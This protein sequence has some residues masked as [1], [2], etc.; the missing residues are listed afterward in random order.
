MNKY[1]LLNYIFNIEYKNQY[2]LILFVNSFYK[3]SGCIYKDEFSNLKEIEFFIKNCIKNNN[4]TLDSQLSKY[5]LGSKKLYKKSNLQLNT[6]NHNDIEYYQILKNYLLIKDIDEFN[7]I[8]YDEPDIQ[9][10][11]LI[12]YYLAK[13]A[14]KNVNSSPHKLFSI[15][16]L[17]DFFSDDKKVEKYQNKIDMTYT[18]LNKIAKKTN[19]FNIN[20]NKSSMYHI[21]EIIK[22]NKYLYKVLISIRNL[23][24]TMY[25]DILLGIKNKP[26]FWYKKLYCKAKPIEN[27]PLKVA[28]HLHLYYMS[29]TDEFISYL[30]NIPQS[31]DLFVTVSEDLIKENKVNKLRDNFENFK[32]LVLPSNKG[33]DIGSFIYFLHNINLDDYDLI[34]KIHTKKTVASSFEKYLS[35]G[36]AFKNSNYKILSNDLWRKHNL[37]AILG[38]KKIVSNIFKTFQEKTIGMIGDKAFLLNSADANK[39]ERK[40]FNDICYKLK[41]TKDMCFFAGTLF[42]IRAD[43]LQKIKDNYTLDSFGEIQESQKAGKL[44]HGFERIFGTLVKSQGYDIE[45]V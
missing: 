38:G 13:Y 35:Q 29:L 3:D 2:D 12:P 4:E 10:A 18:D 21:K 1:Y 45:G 34:L 24:K 30:K 28:V 11:E 42:W 25:F 14:L 43:L 36:I 8:F 31:F 23:L 22:N 40:Y 20:D 41:L 27:N 33:R 17:F 32:L 9:D 16:V 19:V 5:K 15:T 39:N 44:E 26:I 37:D 7:K 6:K